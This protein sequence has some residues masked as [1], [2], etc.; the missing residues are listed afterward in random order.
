MNFSK[1]QKSIF[2]SV[3]TNFYFLHVVH[4]LLFSYRFC[5]IKE[6][7]SYKLRYRNSYLH[8]AVKFKMPR[9]G[10]KLQKWQS[11]PGWQSSPGWRYCIFVLYCILF[12][13]S[14]VVYIV[15]MQF[16][17]FCTILECNI[18]KW[19]WSVIL[20]WFRRYLFDITSTLR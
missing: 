9:K 10:E 17:Q 4:L 3:I 11:Y 14:N 19:C 15:L 20:H 1:Y 13:I 7:F 16:K 12:C 2:Y 8:G 5:W 18:P 6:V